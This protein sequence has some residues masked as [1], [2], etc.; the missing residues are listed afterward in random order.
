M[1][2]LH[3]HQIRSQ[4]APAGQE[5][6]STQALVLQLIEDL[7]ELA[8][9]EDTVNLRMFKPACEQTHEHYCPA[10]HRIQC[11]GLDEFRNTLESPESPWTL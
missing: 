3:F 1:M 11:L 5:E 4:P 10:N 9:I 6:V 2:A 8:S 7:H